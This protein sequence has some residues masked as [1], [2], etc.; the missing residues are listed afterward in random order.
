MESGRHSRTR[1]S[2]LQRTRLASGL[3]SKSVVAI[4]RRALARVLRRQ[5]PAA[6]GSEKALASR[7]RKVSIMP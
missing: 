4:G 1:V 6:I 5:R 2:S 3:E 7:V